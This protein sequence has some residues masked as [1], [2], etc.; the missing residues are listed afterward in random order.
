MGAALALVA[1]YSEGDKST[2][3]RAVPCA[4]SGVAVIS[5]ETS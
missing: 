5:Q 3:N 1:F 4:V 2:H